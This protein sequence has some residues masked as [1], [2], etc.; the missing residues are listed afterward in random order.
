M[1]TEALEGA[2]LPEG[3]DVDETS[4]YFGITESSDIVHQLMEMDVSNA[5]TNFFASVSD[6]KQSACEQQGEASRTSAS[7]P[8]LD[9]LLHLPSRVATRSGTLPARRAT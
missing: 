4:A 7:G 8:L 6:T 2:S 5:L 3:I 9:L 1:S